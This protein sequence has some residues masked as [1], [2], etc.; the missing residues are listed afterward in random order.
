MTEKTPT[1]EELKARRR[2]ELFQ[3]DHWVLP[4]EIWLGGEVAVELE[5]RLTSLGWDERQIG[6]FPLAADEAFINAVMYGSFGINNIEGP[7]KKI[8]REKKAAEFEASGQFKD[9]HV[10]VDLNLTAEEVL[11]DIID[12]GPGFSVAAIPDPTDPSRLLDYT[13]RGIDIMKKGCDRA[14]FKGNTITLY[15]KRVH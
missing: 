13:G 9:R 15:K 11:V 1:T 12:Q 5:E 8:V 14:E 3:G 10:C 2:Q 6:L 7:D 4:P